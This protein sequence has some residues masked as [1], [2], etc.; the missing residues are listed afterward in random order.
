MNITF[1]Y[2][3]QQHTLSSADVTPAYEDEEHG[4]ADD[5]P[6]DGCR[7]AG[8]ENLGDAGRGGLPDRAVARMSQWCETQNL[9][10]KKLESPK[11]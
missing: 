8:P 6:E 1:S 11:I 3:Q 10:L 7:H 2:K 4:C 9:I 5:V